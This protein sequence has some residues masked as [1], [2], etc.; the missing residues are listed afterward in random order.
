ME[1]VKPTGRGGR[2]EGAGRPK[3]T[4]KGY[5][6]A[7]PQRQ[8]RAYEEEWELIKAFGQIVKTDPER[9]RRIMKTE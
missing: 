6:T 9:A 7:R 2:R 1:E 8:M 3:G 5:S 4:L